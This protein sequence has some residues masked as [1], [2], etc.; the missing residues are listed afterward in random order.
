MLLMVFLR[1]ITKAILQASLIN[2]YQEK[3]EISKKAKAGSPGYV[4]DP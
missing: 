3:K 2:L 1:I 4:Y